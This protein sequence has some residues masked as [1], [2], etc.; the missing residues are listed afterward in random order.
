MGVL[1]RLETLSGVRRPLGLR[2]AVVRAAAAAVRTYWAWLE[3][4]HT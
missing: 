4:P 3:T 1:A 2:R